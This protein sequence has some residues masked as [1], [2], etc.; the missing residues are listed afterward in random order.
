MRLNQLFHAALAALFLGV[1]FAPRAARPDGLSLRIDPSS[2]LWIEGDSTLHKW[3][4]R[5]Q[6]FGATFELAPGAAT[7]DASATSIESLVR[8]NGLASATLR[9][10]VV[11]LR[12]GED[13]LDKNLRAALHAE[14]APMIELHI[15]A[16]KAEEHAG[17]LGLTLSGTLSV[18]GVSREIEVAAEAA[19]TAEGGLRITGAHEVRMTDYQVEPPVLM[20]GAIKTADAVQVKF[21]LLLVAR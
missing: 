9:I 1:L 13:G 20:L 11:A 18:A 21:D 14:R 6:S 7:P 19:P 10:P 5:A 2:K 16:C 12:S 4:A 17:T 8:A 3:S 15:R